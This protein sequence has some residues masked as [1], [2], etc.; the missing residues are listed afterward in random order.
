MRTRRSVALVA[1][2]AV[3]AL[4]GTA[5]AGAQ[6]PAQGPGS[7]AGKA[8]RCERF[9]NALAAL[10]RSTTRLEQ[11]IARVEAR[12]AA[13]QLSP[14]KLARAQA[15]VARL[16]QRLAKREALVDRLEAKHAEKCPGA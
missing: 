10:D 12:I 4:G 13:A 6:G 8:K 7:E 5:T 11:R 16:K 1:T 3:L 15:F 14:E 9:G 2:A